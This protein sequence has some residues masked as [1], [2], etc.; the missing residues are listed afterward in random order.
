LAV[1]A[2]GDPARWLKV[3]TYTVCTKENPRPKPSKSYLQH[4]IDGA[5]MWKLPADY[6]ES[7]RT[8]ETLQLSEADSAKALA[9]EIATEVIEKNPQLWGELKEQLNAGYDVDSYGSM[10]HME[11]LGAVT[12]AVAKLTEAERLLLKIHIQPS[13][14]AIT[15]WS[16]IDH[17]NGQI[18]HRAKRAAARS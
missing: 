4:L 18:F 7:L 14:D 9:R 11:F 5:E 8:I 3:F 2:E 13:P 12:N 15:T 17:I 16:F 10:M 6:V 1:Q